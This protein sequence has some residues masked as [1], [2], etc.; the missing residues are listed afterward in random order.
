MVSLSVYNIWKWSHQRNSTLS[1]AKC[2]KMVIKPIE[3]TI[4][5]EMLPLASRIHF[6]YTVKY[7]SYSINPILLCKTRLQLK[8]QFGILADFYLDT[9]SQELNLMSLGP[10]VREGVCLLAQFTC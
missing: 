4:C 6:Y 2:L 7:N 10:G 9:A 3:H 1:I 8:I 5:T